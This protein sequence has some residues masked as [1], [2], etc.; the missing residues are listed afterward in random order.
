MNVATLEASRSERRA[1]VRGATVFRPILIETEDF[2]GFCLVRNL[3]QHGMRAR[4]YTSLAP[5]QPLTVQFTSAKLVRGQVIW[6]DGEHVGVNFDVALD[7][8]EVL[9]ELASN[10]VDGKLNRPLRLPISAPAELMIDGRNIPARV[11]NISQRGCKLMTSS[12]RPGE[13]LTLRLEG[14]DERKCVVR[15]T[16]ADVAGL[17]FIRPLTFEELARWVVQRQIPDDVQQ[18]QPHLENPGG[19]GARPGVG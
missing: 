15:W 14:L 4:V 5:D 17:N 11:Q 9:A 7:V 3:S 19:C 8:A 16:Q 6:C 10:T 18:P 13:E 2:A 1:E 12:V